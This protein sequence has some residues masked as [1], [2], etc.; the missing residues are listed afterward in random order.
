MPISSSDGLYW[1]GAILGS[2]IRLQRE[3]A[4]EAITEKIAKPLGLS[5]EDAALGILT[6]A[7]FNMSLAVRAV[8]VEQGYDRRDRVSCPVA[9]AERSM[10][11]R[12]PESLPSRG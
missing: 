1:A 2:G 8:S 7:N 3:R 5:L 6:I 9:E 10:P 4:A 12:L 11:W